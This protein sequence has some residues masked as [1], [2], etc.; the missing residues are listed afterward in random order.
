MNPLNALIDILPAKCR[1][2]IIYFLLPVGI[3]VYGIWQASGGDWNVFWPAL[4]AAIVGLIAHANT[5][6][7]SL[8]VPD[9]DPSDQPNPDAPA[10]AP[11]GPEM[12]AAVSNTVGQY[13]DDAFEY[14]TDEEI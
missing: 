3:F 2:W 14:P 13:E 1:K 10:V 9:F 6:T 4:G 12:S 7:P 5:A 11:S 8:K